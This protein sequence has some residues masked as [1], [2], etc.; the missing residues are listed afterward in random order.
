M[1]C[2]AEAHAAAKLSTSAFDRS[3]LRQSRLENRD[4]ATKDAL[5][6][7]CLCQTAALITTQLNVLRSV[8]RAAPVAALSERAEPSTHLAV[9]CNVF[10]RRAN[11]K[12]SPRLT[13]QQDAKV[14]AQCS[15]CASKIGFC[16]RNNLRCA[17]S[18]NCGDFPCL[19]ASRRLL[20]RLSCREDQTFFHNPPLH[21]HLK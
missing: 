1:R 17:C 14:E 11:G 12:P 15:R 13:V 19:S 21:S 4:I 9:R 8:E 16:N 18:N 5:C 7:P 3:L 20:S 2:S 6:F 10:W